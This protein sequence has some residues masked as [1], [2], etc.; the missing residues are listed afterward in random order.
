MDLGK[1]D[2]LKPCSL[3]K[4]A[5]ILHATFSNAFY[6]KVLILIYFHW[7]MFLDRTH[8]KSALAQ[9]IVWH[10]TSDQAITWTNADPVHRGK[11]A[12]PYLDV[13]WLK[14][15]YIVCSSCVAATENTR[16]LLVEQTIIR[17]QLHGV[18]RFQKNTC[19]TCIE[20]VRIR[21]T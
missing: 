13:S 18:T 14:I 10:G 5:D 6:W 19:T 9:V 8:N 20:N 17:I 16:M 11:Y 21:F 7:N 15:K 3:N 4:M 1:G 2:W 12:S